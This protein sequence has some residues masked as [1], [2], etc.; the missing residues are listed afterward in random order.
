M[1]KSLVLLMCLML[2]RHV[3][4][5]ESVV[6]QQMSIVTLRHVLVNTAGQVS[7]VMS[8]VTTRYLSI[9]MPRA[10]DS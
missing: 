9:V 1:F 7:V 6:V 10:P 2:H 4:L 3:S 8:L 5:H